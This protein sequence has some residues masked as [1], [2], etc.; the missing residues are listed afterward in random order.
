MNVAS[1]LLTSSPCARHAGPS[2]PVLSRSHTIV[3]HSMFFPPSIVTSYQ[4]L[5]GPTVQIFYILGLSS[6]FVVDQKFDFGVV[7][8]DALIG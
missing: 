7:G 8:V 3:R 5:H 6:L 2:I 4:F 1:V